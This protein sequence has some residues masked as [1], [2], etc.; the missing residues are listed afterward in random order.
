MR[1]F[2]KFLF[3]FLVVYVIASR[4][5]AWWV[6]SWWFDEVGYRRV[7]LV[8]LSTRLALFACGAFGVAAFL[9][10]NIRIAWRAE[11]H[12]RLEEQALEKEVPALLRDQ[13]FEPPELERYRH[14]L[15]VLGVGAMALL[16]GIA[17]GLNW[18]LWLRLTNAVK[19]G[20]TDPVF[21]R[22]LGFYLF[23]LPALQFLWLYVFVLLG[24]ALIT[25]FVIY[26]QE[27]EFEISGSTTALSPWAL[28]HMAAL[29]AALLVWKAV[30]YQLVSYN[31]LLSRRS[32]VFGIGYTDFY[33]RLPLLKVMMLIAL[34]CAGSL[35]WWSRRNDVRRTGLTFCA[36]VAAS[37]VLLVIVPGLFQHLSVE[38]NDGREA[39][40]LDWQVA[41]TKQ[42]Y[43]LSA[44]G[45]RQNWNVRAT[46]MRP[47]SARPASTRPTVQIVTNAAAGF[48][49]WRRDALLQVLNEMFEDGSGH[50]T[51]VDLDRYRI[52]DE[53]RPVFVAARE[54]MPLTGSA[55]LRPGGILRPTTG[56]TPE[57]QPTQSQIGASWIDQ[58]LHQTHG[59]GLLICDANRTD[60]AGR[61]LIYSAEMLP[62]QQVPSQRDRNSVTSTRNGTSSP[63][64]VVR[65][66]IFFGEFPVY[67]PMLP[68]PLRSQV[69][70]SQAA[71]VTALPL[72]PGGRASLEVGQRSALPEP[73]GVVSSIPVAVAAPVPVAQYVVVH[74]PG[75]A[76]NVAPGATS[77]Y[78]GKAGVPIETKWRQWLMA[79]RFHDVRLALS[80][81]V[82][83]QSRV[84]WHRRVVERCRNIAP[85]LS[86]VDSDPY[87]VLT[88]DGR[89]VW[90]LDIYSTSDSYP[91]SEPLDT[92]TG[93]NYLRGSIKATVDAYDGTVNFYIADSSD[94]VVQCYARAFPE[95][96]QPLSTMPE[97]LRRHA[98]YPASAL[99]AQSR[100]WAR[101]RHLKN[102]APLREVVTIPDYVALPNAPV[103][104]GEAP[105][106]YSTRSKN[107]GESL[108]APE[109]FA[110][111]FLVTAHEAE[112]ASTVV[113]MDLSRHITRGLLADGRYDGPYSDVPLTQRLW[114]WTPSAKVQLSAQYSPPPADQ[115]GLLPGRV[116]SIRRTRAGAVPLGDALLGVQS[117]WENPGGRNPQLKEVIFQWNSQVIRAESFDAALRELRATAL[118]ATMSQP[119][120]APPKPRAAPR[121]AEV[122]ERARAQFDA[123]QRARRVSDWPAY[124]AAEKKLGE[125]LRSLPAQ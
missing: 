123:M 55:M 64:R 69:A 47:A 60:A 2:L 26:G 40:F 58:H 66:E 35:W 114:L 51:D 101:L 62:S 15:V 98:R 37:T 29:G 1:R 44:L 28:R 122:L 45:S 74:T 91:Y 89:I 119:V 27:N 112:R 120:T 79:W 96:F 12:R 57:S 59:A 6:E 46:S 115:P 82:D 22:D 88:E 67:Q 86:F 70:L 78:S 7:Y 21:G 99:H 4:L 30:G 77:E 42:A 14:W 93:W 33:L 118:L 100:A 63:L 36:Y 80:N 125:L 38:P 85:F 71:Q 10:L 104:T 13:S 41:A 54:L 52:G 107:L 65:P 83:V 124:G 50:F 20:S 76:G 94:A 9:W 17:A 75:A 72:A 95:L 16:G 81:S 8:L 117:Q 53:V 34:V 105:I 73:G 97:D 43:G 68:Q 116:E 25:V 23:Q 113:E 18:P 5:A 87:P 108:A 49:L 110:T 56:A 106:E 32:T 11:N 90:L 39:R 102:D 48:P 61:P 103:A 111:T 3:W 24:L 19:V 31:L 92:V 121:P 84:L 109:F